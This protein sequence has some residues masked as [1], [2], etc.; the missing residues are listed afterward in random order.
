MDPPDWEKIVRGELIRLRDAKLYRQPR[1]V[2]PIDAT[3]V[4]IDGRSLVNFAS[5]NYLGLTH[6]PK[7]VSAVRDAVGSG[8]APLITGY[9][10]S[11][12]SAERT[13]ATWKQTGA[14]V[15]LP[16]GYQ[17]NLA[18]VQTLAAMA[19][20]AG[21]GVRFLLDKLSHAS[22]IDAVRGTA[23]RGREGQTFRIFPHN[24]LIK[25]RRLLREAG[26][27][28]TQVVV[29]ESI[30]SMDGDAADLVGLAQLKREHPFLLMLDEAHGSGVYGPNGSGLAAE[31]GL[32]ALPDVVVATFSKALGCV[33]AAV[34]SREAFCKLLVNSAR[35]FIYS[36]APPSSVAAA[37]EAAIGVLHDEPARQQRV[38]SLALHVRQELGAAGIRIPTGDSPILPILLGSEQAALQGAQRL[39]E[40]GLFVVPI[41]PPTVPRGSSRLR[42]TL[43]C[44]HS[45]EEVRQLIRSVASAIKSRA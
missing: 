8:A 3:H 21:G 18:A 38:R 4:E 20:L 14:A 11:H 13:V 23:G 37:V 34:C 43:S 36:T 44:E 32:S 41:R 12:A 29:T 28:Q 24:D 35:P 25:L 33:G 30:F 16:S 26:P 15:L 22:L 5:N 19:E 39:L 40:D 6:H 45:E 2:R 9:T 17:A 1:I 42:I 31:R 7:V 10:P 27:G